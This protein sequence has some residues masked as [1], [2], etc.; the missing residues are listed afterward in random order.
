MSNEVLFI[1]GSPSGASRSSAVARL[2]AD[3]VTRAGLT[4]V[5]LGLRDFEP[6]DLVFGS[7]QS[8]SV[9]RLVESAKAARALVLSSPMYKATYSG[10]LKAIVDLVPPDALTGKP[11]LGIATTRQASHGV[12]VDRAYRALFDFFSARAVDTL[13]V[14]DAAIRVSEGEAT[15]DPDAERR[16]REAGRALAH[17]LDRAGAG[18]TP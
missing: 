18:R 13:V 6:A 12:L 1:A 4:P 9:A 8:P 11:A 17:A 5:V 16:A 3:E 10:G 15:L 2:V 7:T 14:A